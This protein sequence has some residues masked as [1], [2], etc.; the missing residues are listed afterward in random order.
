MVTVLP[1]ILISGRYADG[2]SLRSFINNIAIFDRKFEALEVRFELAHETLQ[3][4][5]G[6]IPATEFFSLPS[7]HKFMCHSLF[8]VASGRD[9]LL[10]SSRSSINVTVFFDNYYGRR[11][12]SLNNKKM[13]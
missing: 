1:Y 5:H 2:W 13:H 3:Q 12:K 8:L 7:Y 6:N 10:L 9:L 11:F 4:H